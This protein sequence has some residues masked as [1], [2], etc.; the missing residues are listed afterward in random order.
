VRSKNLARALLAGSLLLA[1]P[2]C[3]DDDGNDTDNIQDDVNEGVDNLQEDVNEGVD[4][5]Q[6]GDDDGS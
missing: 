3:G 2:A 1:V 4:D 6:D 5:L